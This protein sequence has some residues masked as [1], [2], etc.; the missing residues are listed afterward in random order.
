MRKLRQR[1]EVFA[2][3]IQSHLVPKLFSPVGCNIALHERA[4]PCVHEQDPGRSWGQA[5]EYL[6]MSR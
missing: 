2:Q 3:T 1:N 4:P 5:V 6:L